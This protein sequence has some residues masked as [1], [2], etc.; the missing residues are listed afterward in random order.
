MAPQSAN[1]PKCPQCG[2]ANHPE[3]VSCGLCGRRLAGGADLGAKGAPGAYPV[4]GGAGHPPAPGAGGARPW[5]PP[6]PPT[7][8]SY[9]PGPVRPA[10]EP[11]WGLPAEAQRPAS[12]SGQGG[13]N[14]GKIILVAILVFGAAGV[15]FWRYCY[16]FGSKTYRDARGSFEV[17]VPSN[18]RTS[19]KTQ[20]FSGRG[21]TVPVDMHLA[22]GGA[23]I[24]AFAVAVVHMPLQQLLANGGYEEMATGMVQHFFQAIGGT[25]P[26]VQAVNRDGQVAYRGSGTCLKAGKT[27]HATVEVRLTDKRQYVLVII[28]ESEGVLNDERGNQF[29]VSF[30]VLPGTGG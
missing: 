3:A 21:V 28:G 27:L 23:A 7:P 12:G 18:Y 8:P 11:P 19:L 26:V 20:T 17:A 14:V 15:Y 10:G 25:P 13:G 16:G 29:F 9:G 1:R 6:V 30:K 4:P 22:E 2:A 5:T 24:G